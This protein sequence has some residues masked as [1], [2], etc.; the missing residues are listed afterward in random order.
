MESGMF[1]ALRKCS[2]IWGPACSLSALA[3]AVREMISGCGI[4]ANNEKTLFQGLVPFQVTSLELSKG[5]ITL[6]SE[7]NMLIHRCSG[8]RGF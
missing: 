3:L 7:N 4:K 1:E 8:F 5:Y 6:F 2:V